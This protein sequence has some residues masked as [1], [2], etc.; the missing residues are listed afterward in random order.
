MKKT[1]ILLAFVYAVI[2]APSVALAFDVVQIF[3]PACFFACEN[4]KPKKTTTTTVARQTTAQR[5]PAPAPTPAPITVVNNNYN[6]NN[7][8]GNGSYHDY[9]NDYRSRPNYGSLVVSCMQILQLHL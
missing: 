1:L 5:A 3:D 8:N 6:Y 4:N 9:D 7:T 2:S